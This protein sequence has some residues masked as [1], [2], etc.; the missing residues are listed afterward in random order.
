MR[1]WFGP[2][3]GLLAGAALALT[4]VA[5]LMFRFNNPDALLVL[6]MTAA[7]YG[8][9]RAVESGRTRWLVLAGALLG[10]GFLTKMLQAFLVLPGFGLAYLV[11][12]PP[13][14]R[15]RIWQLLAGLA[16]VVVAAGLVGGGGHADARRRPA[17]RRRLD[18]RQHPA[19]R[20]RLQRPR[21]ARRQ[22]D[23][24]GRLRR[25]A[26]AAASP[27][28]GGAAG[29]RR[30][31]GSEMGGQ[32][33]W[34]L[35]AALLAI[36]VLGWLAWRARRR[37]A[38]G[39]RTGWRTDRDL[40]AALLW[41][42]WLLVTGAVFSFMAG[43]IHPYYTVALA[44]AIAALTGIGAVQLW[45]LRAELAGPC[46]CWR[47]ASW[48]RRAGRSSLLD[49]SPGWYPWLRFVILALGLVAAGGLLAAPVLAGRT[50]AAHRVGA[51]LGAV[52][53]ACGD[54]RGPG[55][56]DGLQRGHR[57]HGAHRRAADGRAG[58]DECVRRAGRRQ[59][60]RAGGPAVPGWRRACRGPGALRDQAPAGG[61][62]ARRGC[63]AGPAAPAGRR[64]GSRVTGGGFLAT[65]ARARAGR[66]GSAARRRSARR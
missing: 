38:A 46:R 43:I 17:L 45:R 55:R 27:S 33:S 32:I 34:L 9:V 3:A 12:G 44:P 58:C 52:A 51:T 50:A 8:T 65:A 1:R 19:A 5:A 14:L 47:W 2:A 30:L 22:R 62:R 16:A 4:P 18:Q 54:R 40:A 37:V 10:F 42:G 7:A 24:L 36:A 21:P 6:L 39:S 48:S 35:P 20:A 31:F 56:A 57:R 23:R 61:H 41:G 15:R 25:R 53:A 28:F 66:A 13:R 11:A 26:R 59:A 60:V 64:L 49:R 29:L 63:R